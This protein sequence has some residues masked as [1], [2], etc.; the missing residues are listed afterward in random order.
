MKPICRILNE[1]IGLT[2]IELMIVLVL[3]IVL[4][5][6]VYLA[7]QIQQVSDKEQQQVTIAQQDLRAVMLVMERDLR[8]AGC[9]PLLVNSPTNMIFGVQAP[10]SDSSLVISFDLD[11]D[12][13]LD[14]G[15]RVTY[16]LVDNTLQRD[17]GSPSPRI[18]TENVSS[19]HFEYLDVDG[20]PTTEPSDIRSIEVKID[21]QSP[22]GEFERTLTRRIKLRNMGL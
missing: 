20:S 19:I 16:S 22:D 7:F 12:G 11:A 2:L 17:D 1:N 6:T 10:L 15:E 3:S 5:G 4:M 13:T 14:T 21:V 18:L 9:D 8:N